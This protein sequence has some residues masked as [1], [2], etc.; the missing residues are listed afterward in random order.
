MKLPNNYGC[1]F[2]LSGKRRR[3]YAVRVKIGDKDNALPSTNIW[4]ILKNQQMPIHSW[5]NT[6]KAL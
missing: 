2:K 5:P 4:A 3:P 1:V 6:T